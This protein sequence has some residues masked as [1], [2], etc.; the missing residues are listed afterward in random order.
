MSNMEKSFSRLVLGD[1][2]PNPILV[3]LVKVKY[4]AVMYLVL[5]L[6][7]LVVTFSMYGSLIWTANVSNQPVAIKGTHMEYL[8]APLGL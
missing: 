1:M 3:R 4:R 5:I 8:H 6:G 7:P 2:L